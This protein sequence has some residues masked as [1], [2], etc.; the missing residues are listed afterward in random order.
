MPVA[1]TVV[2]DL[3]PP[4]HISKRIPGLTERFIRY[5]MVANTRGFRDRC[6]VK[7]AP[8]K[9]LVDVRALR[10]WLEEARGLPA[11]MLQE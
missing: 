10:L 9:M 6:C 8:R 4:K 2:M 5:Q 11:S 7:V 1:D 3:V